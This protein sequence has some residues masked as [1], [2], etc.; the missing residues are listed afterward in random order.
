M[1]GGGGDETRRGFILG[2]WRR[3]I[4]ESMLMAVGGW[5]GR[6]IVW[7]RCTGSNMEMSG[8]SSGNKVLMNLLRWD[9]EIRAER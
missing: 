1:H 4:V 5:G 9:S 2:A 3:W 8:F 6:A 7:Q